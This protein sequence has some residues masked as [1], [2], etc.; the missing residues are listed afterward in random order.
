MLEVWQ[1]IQSKA[2]RCIDEVYPE[3]DDNEQFFPANDFL[4]EAAKIVARAVPLRALGRGAD[5][6]LDDFIP[7]ADGHAELPLPEDFLRL[8]S[9]KMEGWARNADIIHDEDVRYPQQSN[10]TLR[11][12]EVNPVVAI[13]DETRLECYS[14]S[15]GVYAQVKAATYF[16]TPDTEKEYPEKLLDITAWKVAEL[17]LSSMN[18]AAAQIAAQKV[19]DYLALL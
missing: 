18:D 13:C 8:L 1:K 9:F 2:L 4:V 15:L 17:T 11:G 16:P 7:Y 6:P 3:H 10:K 12:G 19:N 5:I 14:S